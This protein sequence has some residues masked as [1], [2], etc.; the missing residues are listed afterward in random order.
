MCN[1]LLIVFIIDSC[2]LLTVNKYRTSPIGSSGSV[3]RLVIGNAYLASES[4]AP[5]RWG[6]SYQ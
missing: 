6:G 4:S 5:R 3:G 1:H 2:S